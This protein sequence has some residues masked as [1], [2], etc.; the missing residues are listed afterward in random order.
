MPVLKER[1]FP[2]IYVC[3][4]YFTSGQLIKQ[5]PGADLRMDEYG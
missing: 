4:D 1:G 2:L 3:L 5:G